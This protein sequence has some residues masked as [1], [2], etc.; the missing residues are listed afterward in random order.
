MYKRQPQGVREY[1]IIGEQGNQIRLT[2]FR[3]YGF[4]GKE[5]LVYRPGRASGER[6]LQ[7]QLPSY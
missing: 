6:S 1:E 7:L 4:M 3:T 2:L 5:N